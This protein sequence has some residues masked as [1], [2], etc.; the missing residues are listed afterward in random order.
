LLNGDAGGVILRIPRSLPLLPPLSP[1]LNWQK[2]H[3]PV[4]VWSDLIGSGVRRWLLSGG[5]GGGD[6]MVPGSKARVFFSS[7]YLDLIQA[8]LLVNM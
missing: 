6:E 1:P 2:E 8:L 4:V 7:L 5:G 3:Y